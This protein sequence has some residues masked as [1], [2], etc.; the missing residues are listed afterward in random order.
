MYC[1]ISRWDPPSPRAPPHTSVC[2]SCSAEFRNNYRE[3][4][5]LRHKHEEYPWAPL[6][7]PGRAGPNGLPNHVQLVALSA[8]AGDTLITDVVSVLQLRKATFF[9]FP[10]HRENLVFR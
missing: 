5:V 3:L 4:S 8:V 2:S 9:C 10:E 6:L 1:T 7:P